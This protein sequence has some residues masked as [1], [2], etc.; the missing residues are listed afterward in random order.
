MD[1][2]LP[3]LLDRKQL[4][5]ELGVTR[6]AVDAIFRSLPVVALPNLRKPFVRRAD[7]RELLERSTHRDGSV[8]R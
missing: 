8:V 2:P 6:A 5:A 1:D 3:E 4:A 7:V